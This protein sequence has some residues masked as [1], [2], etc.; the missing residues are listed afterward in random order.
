MV[1]TD[2]ITVVDLLAIPACQNRPP[3]HSYRNAHRQVV[4]IVIRTRYVSYPS[5]AS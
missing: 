5:A 3:Q 4:E 2:H 1:C